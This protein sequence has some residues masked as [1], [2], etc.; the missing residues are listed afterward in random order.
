M[1]QSMLH[2]ALILNYMRLKQNLFCPFSLS[3]S[4][5]SF[6]YF[7]KSEISTVCHNG[8][9]NYINYIFNSNKIESVKYVSYSN[10]HA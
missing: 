8:K 6:L 1:F 9:V 2:I 4:L 7:L 3:R 10:I 5:I